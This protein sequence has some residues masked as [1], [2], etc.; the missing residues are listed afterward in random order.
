MPCEVVAV[1]QAEVPPRFQ[2]WMD[3]ASWRNV[4]IRRLTWSLVV[5]AIG[6][7]VTRK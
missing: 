5:T 2:T 7:A 3:L 4:R 6:S 1:L